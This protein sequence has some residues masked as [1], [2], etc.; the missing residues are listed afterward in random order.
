MIKSQCSFPEFLHWLQ[1]L[2]L[3]EKQHLEGKKEKLLKKSNVIVQC[4]LDYVRKIK[5]AEKGWSCDPQR[6]CVVPE[7]P[8]RFAPV[9]NGSIIKCQLSARRCIFITSTDSRMVI[10]DNITVSWIALANLAFHLQYTSRW[11]HT[12]RLLSVCIYSTVFPF[13]FG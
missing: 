7:P 12:E 11:R 3:A 9:T 4:F 6:I 8:M 1:T 2:T 5:L 10:Q 13:I